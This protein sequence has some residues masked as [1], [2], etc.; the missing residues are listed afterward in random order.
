MESH[1]IAQAGVQ[2]HDLGSLQHLSP[3]SSSSSSPTS[4]SQKSKACEKVISV[5]QT[6]ITKHRNTRYYSCRVMAVTSQTFYEVMFD[7]GS[8]S[9]DTFPEDIVRWYPIVEMVSNCV[10]QAGLKLMGSSDPPA[11]ASQSAV[12]TE[13]GLTI[14]PRLVLNSWAQLILLPQPPKERQSIKD[15]EREVPCHRRVG[16]AVLPKL[17]SNYWAQTILSPQLPKFKPYEA[18]VLILKGRS[19]PLTKEEADV[20]E[21]KACGRAQWLTPVIPALWE[22]EVGGSQGQE[23]ETILAN[24]VEPHLY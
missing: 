5:G 1:S 8:F 22:A 3:R 14:M 17:I 20:I 6:V 12:I 21:L 11:S 7:D 10:A 2:W 24:T 9:R 23:I 18:K 15:A 19:S 4:A 13:M 16:L